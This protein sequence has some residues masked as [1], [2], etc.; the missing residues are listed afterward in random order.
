M[1][2][3]PESTPGHAALVGTG[4][5]AT[6]FESRS[7]A[8]GYK[9][10]DRCLAKVDDDEPIFVLRAQDVSSTRAIRYWLEI[11]RATLPEERIAETEACMRD[12]DD[13]QRSNEN[14]VKLPD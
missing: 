9:K 5:A 7:H 3:Q 6:L 1:T 8:M 10:D 2:S 12:F 13:W 14:R 4:R 11:N